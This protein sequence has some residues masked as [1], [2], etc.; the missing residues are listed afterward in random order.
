MI[1]KQKSKPVFERLTHFYCINQS[2]RSNRNLKCFDVIDTWYIF[3][4]YKFVFNILNNFNFT[5]NDKFQTSAA[6]GFV[7]EFLFTVQA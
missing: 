2:K 7:M 3:A 5:K 6:S 1:M 4:I